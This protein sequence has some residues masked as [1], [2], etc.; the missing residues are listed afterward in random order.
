MGCT[1]C[2]AKKA[3]AQQPRV[4]QGQ[5]SF[6]LTMPDGSAT[7]FGSQLEANAANARAGYTGVVRPSL[8]GA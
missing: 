1:P 3:G 8:T 2:S 7:T 6:T 5:Q 4:Y